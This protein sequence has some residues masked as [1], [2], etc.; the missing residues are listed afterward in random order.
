M[1][2]PTMEQAVDYP[3]L[4]KKLERVLSKGNKRTLRDLGSLLDK[5]DLDTD[6]RSIL[7]R[8]CLLQN[9][10]LICDKPIER[11]F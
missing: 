4:L 2:A 1:A 5:N 3:L 7:E 11:I 9:P 8:H 10:K 6:V